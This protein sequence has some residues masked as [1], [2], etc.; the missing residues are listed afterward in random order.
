MKLIGIS[1]TNG[2]GK[3]SLGEL[4]AEKHNYLFVSVSDLLRIEAKKRGLSTERVH[5]AEISAE[6]RREHGF[7]V[8]VDKSVELYNE[9]GGDTTFDGLAIAS[10]RHPYEADY[11]KEIG[12]TMVWTDADSKVRYNRIFSRGRHDDDKTFEQ[13][14]AEEQAEMKRSGDSATLDM[15]AVRERCDITVVNNG[16]TLEAFEAVVI[17]QLG[18]LL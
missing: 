4:L 16:D 10:I 5:L 3:D 7:N 18:V 11:I 6:W 2:S 14:V 1:G 8:L 9:K 12:G 17:E 13:F 15:E